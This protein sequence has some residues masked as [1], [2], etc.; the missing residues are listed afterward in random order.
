MVVPLKGQIVQQ[1][2]TAQYVFRGNL[3]I[4]TDL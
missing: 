2:D 4:S 1:R 3:E